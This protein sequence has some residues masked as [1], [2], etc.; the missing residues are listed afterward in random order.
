[1]SNA[2]KITATQQQ[3]A[4]TMT[5][6]T[7]AAAPTAPLTDRSI[8]GM[9]CER[10]RTRRKTRLGRARVRAHEQKKVA[11]TAAASRT[12][13]P[14]T[15]GAKRGEQASVASTPKHVP[16]ARWPRCS[17]R[18]GVRALYKSRHSPRK[19]TFSHYTSVCVYT[20]DPNPIS[21]MNTF[22]AVSASASD[23]SQRPSST[24]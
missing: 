14:Q 3:I 8:A 20:A 12:H 21:N 19:G 15:K 1:M 4:T 11:T 18:G 24:E 9:P 22:T 2:Q 10:K 6:P 17:V 7:A 5:A 23:R 13:H 16:I